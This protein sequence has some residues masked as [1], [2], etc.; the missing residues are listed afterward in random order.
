[1]AAV[2]MKT[3]KKV[4]GDM[5]GMEVL[6]NLAKGAK[7][8]AAFGIEDRQLE[9]VYAIGLGQY[10]QGRYD[11]AMKLF[12]FISFHDP[13]FMKA[14][15]GIG[16]C[17]QMLGRHQEALVYLG[18]AI[19]DDDSDLQTAVQ[20]AES[21]VHVGQREDA[22]LLLKRITRELARHGGNDYTQRKAEGLVALLV[23]GRT[24]VT[25]SSEIL[26]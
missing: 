12:A 3:S 8:G 11:D 5:S 25:T 14:F 4:S 10:Q 18:L 24:A 1:M 2:E 7:L 17:L 20:I 23:Q 9:A 21:L 19:I 22:H 6:D 16:S 26:H 13:T 15:K